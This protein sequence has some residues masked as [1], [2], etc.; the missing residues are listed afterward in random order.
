MRIYGMSTWPCTTA[1][2][3]G[4]PTDLTL[5]KGAQADVIGWFTINR[6]ENKPTFQLS[7]A[8]GGGYKAK[9]ILDIKQ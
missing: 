6:P 7:D 4:D 5:G 1:Y 9:S 8:S 2:V 3:G